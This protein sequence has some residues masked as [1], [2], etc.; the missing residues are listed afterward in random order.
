MYSCKHNFRFVVS[1]AYEFETFAIILVSVQFYHPKTQFLRG[2]VCW[3]K[4]Q[5]QAFVL[6]VSNSYC[7]TESN[8]LHIVWT[9]LWSS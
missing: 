7:Q 2:L 3:I 9:I 6:C 8:M 4:K 5:Q 1:A